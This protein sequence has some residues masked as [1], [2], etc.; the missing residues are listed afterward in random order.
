VLQ[1]GNA[2]KWVNY[3]YYLINLIDSCIDIWK[4]FHFTLI[5]NTSD[6]L[7]ES[8]PSTSKA[9][10]SRSITQENLEK[11]VFCN[12]D[13][14]KADKIPNLTKKGFD[15]LISAA[16]ERSDKTAKFI[17]SYS[18]TGFQKFSLKYHM[19]CKMNYTNK[20]QL[21]I[22]KRRKIDPTVVSNSPPSSKRMSRAIVPT[23]NWNLHCL[24]CAEVEDK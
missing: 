18:K 22:A 12:K 10:C 3:K 9:G 7:K 17:L 19:Y 4:T 15:T 23:F 6:A 20:K 8:E 2:V 21:E 11:C 1:S 13:I 24:I 5:F 14:S 16:T